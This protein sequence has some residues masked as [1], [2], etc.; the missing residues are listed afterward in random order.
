MIKDR[1]PTAEAAL[2]QEMTVRPVLYSRAPAW[3]R[4]NFVAA[5]PK[6]AEGN[7]IMTSPY[8]SAG[9]ALDH[10]GDSGRFWL[11]IEIH[12]D[13]KDGEAA[14]A[15]MPHSKIEIKDTRQFSIR[16]ED[17]PVV[18]GSEVELRPG[19]REHDVQP[20]V[21]TLAY[22]PVTNEVTWSPVTKFS[23]HDK[24]ELHAITVGKESFLSS[25]DHS[26][27]A[28]SKE[29][30]RVEK[31]PPLA[32]RTVNRRECNLMAPVSRNAGSTAGELIDSFPGPFGRDVAAT[33]E[34]GFALGIYVGDG[35]FSRSDSR[36]EGWVYALY[37]Y[38]GG[39]VSSRRK[40]KTHMDAALT[41][42][43][44]FGLNSDKP[45]YTEYTRESLG[46]KI[47]QSGRTVINAGK[48]QSLMRACHSWLKG[49]CG[50]TAESK[51]FP[52]FVLD[53]CREFRWGMFCGILASDGHIGLNHGKDK[54]QLVVGLNSITSAKLASDFLA[55]CRS[56]N[57][58]SSVSIASRRTS[59]GK[60]E[61]TVSVSTVDLASLWKIQPFSVGCPERDAILAEYLPGVR[62]GNT[63]D[64]LPFPGGELDQV[65]REAFWNLS[66]CPKKG[67]RR[68]FGASASWHAKGKWHR[69]SAE[70]WLP[71]IEGW[72][73]DNRPEMLEELRN[74]SRIVG[75]VNIRWD[76]IHVSDETVVETAYDITV[77]GPYTFATAGG[78]F[79]QDTIAVHTPSLPE[80][81]E[82]AK[83]KLMPSKMLF[84]IRNRDTTLPVPKH[85]MLLGAFSAQLKPSGK[86]HAFANQEEAL[87]AYDAGLVNASDQ[88]IFQPN[89]NGIL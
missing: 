6:L 20:G 78:T 11:P 43:S 49:L 79:V 2:R 68:N 45:S 67:T 37:L 87:R 75:D 63:E 13:S 17:I 33:R 83:N 14:V 54:P 47:G 60:Q 16:I 86:V 57:L 12:V 4:H 65:V 42:W 46:G 85:E 41:L 50:D 80:A 71:G 72:V 52:P 15:S 38:G 21:R 77:P 40:Q 56:L 84:S 70:K 9:L 74:Y 1:H 89:Q 18:P 28:F 7:N 58:G 48:D 76:E 59:T 24:V 39:S 29:T 44:T 25:T 22:H 10:D 35:A 66:G 3:H 34:L 55:L 19:V 73:K 26:L 61:F 82:D 51:S 36:Q 32:T 23:V 62:I 31:M 88:V 53:A 27:L 64:F 69:A 8:T 30:N 5:W 81:V